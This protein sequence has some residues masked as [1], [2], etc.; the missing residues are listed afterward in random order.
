MI[1]I[2]FDARAGLAL[3]TMVAFN[4]CAA[5]DQEPSFKLTAGWYRLSETG[6]GFDVNLRHTSEYGNAWLGAFR[7]SSLNSQQWRA[8]WDRSIGDTWRVQP[9]VQIASGGFVG[10]SLNVEAGTTWVA[11]AGIGRT[12]LRPYYN[13]NFDPNDAWSLLAG[14]RGERGQSIVATYVR[15]NRENPDQQHFHVVMRTPTLDGQRLTLDALYK[16]GLVNG[17]RV[18]KPGITMTYDWPGL[19]V[20]LAYDPKTNFTVDNAWRFSIGTRF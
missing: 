11:G 13:L 5:A 14:Y 12:N 8:G 9:S 7:S 20:R 2:V 3:L 6:D 1:D 16:R 15:D 10:G 19:F 18:G 4:T 17:Q